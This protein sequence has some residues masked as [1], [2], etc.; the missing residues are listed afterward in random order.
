[1]VG[2]ESIVHVY[3]VY[4]METHICNYFSCW[5]GEGL[6]GVGRD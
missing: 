5:A 1:M 2:G 4:L 3:F 6:W